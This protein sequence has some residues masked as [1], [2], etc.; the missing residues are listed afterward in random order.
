MPPKSEPEAEL[1]TAIRVFC[2]DY[3]R[4]SEEP[5]NAESMAALQALLDEADDILA[6]V[7]GTFKDPVLNAAEDTIAADAE[8]MLANCHA[9]IDESVQKLQD[10]ADRLT[11]GDL[12][13][14]PGM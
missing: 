7:E 9:N 1:E 8:E 11:G 2:R 5:D 6:A 3:L 13:Q 12:G 4:M 10:M 14:P